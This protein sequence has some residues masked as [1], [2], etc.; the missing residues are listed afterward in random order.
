MLRAHDHLLV[1]LRRDEAALRNNRRD[2]KLEGAMREF[3]SLHA[4]LDVQL[5]RI[6]ERLALLAM[7][8][9]NLGSPHGQVLALRRADGTFNVRDSEIVAELAAS[10]LAVSSGL[11]EA[12]AVFG[13]QFGSLELASVLR[14]L[15][16]SHQKDASVL[17]AL[18]RE[19]KIP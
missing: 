12:A 15:A 10:H 1:S 13:Q 11:Y 17:R 14:E 3:A 6:G 5:S 16:E 7:H 8:N 18:L 4:L 9:R 19:E 2:S